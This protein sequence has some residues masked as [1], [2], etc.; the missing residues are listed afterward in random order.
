[1]KVKLDWKKK[2]AKK[3]EA[4]PAAAPAADEQKI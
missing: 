3:A 4:E 2:P 1:V